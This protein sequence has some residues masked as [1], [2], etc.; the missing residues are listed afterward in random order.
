[1]PARGRLTP[2]DSFPSSVSLRSRASPRAQTSPG[3]HFRGTAP[4]RLPSGAPATP[5]YPYPFPCNSFRR[6]RHGSFPSL[7]PR[8]FLPDRRFPLPI[9]PTVPLP[10]SVSPSSF[11]SP[12][13]TPKKTS[14]SKPIVHHLKIV[15]VLSWQH[16][17]NPQRSTPP[18]NPSTLWTC[19]R[20]CFGGPQG[21]DLYDRT[22]MHNK[23][24]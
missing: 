8:R 11:P 24:K 20:Y 18:P 1:M 21:C 2:R 13:R 7:S 5:G 6:V 22:Y 23:W 15:K 14:P 17:G 12:C 16:S 9:P 4:F 3:Q 19:R 10:P